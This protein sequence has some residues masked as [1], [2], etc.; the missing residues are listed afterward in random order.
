[1]D[2]FDFEWLHHSEAIYSEREQLQTPRETL[3]NEYHYYNSHEPQPIKVINNTG[4]HTL[5]NFS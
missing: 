3:D 1:M 5:Y 2:D 4:V